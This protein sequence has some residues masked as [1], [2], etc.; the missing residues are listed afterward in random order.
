MLARMR[1]ER[2]DE[3]P[4]TA[5][6]AGGMVDGE[7]AEQRIA[8]VK[9]DPADSEGCLRGAAAEEVLQM[10]RLQIAIREL[11]RGKQ[12]PH[13]RFRGSSK[14]AHRRVQRE[15]GAP[16]KNATSP[17]SRAY[18]APTIMSWF[19]STSSSRIGE[20]WRSALADT[21]TLARTA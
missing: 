19:D 1:L 10:A 20:P 4:A 12:A 6:A 8:T 21:R 9:L 3:R 5:T 11:R 14:D 7:R 2:G 13:R 16:S 15:A 18:S 17:V